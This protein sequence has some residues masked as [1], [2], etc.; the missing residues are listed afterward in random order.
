MFIFAL[1]LIKK[2]DMKKT[3]AALLLFIALSGCSQEKQSTDDYLSNLR[4]RVALLP[5]QWVKGMEFE[6]IVICKTSGRIVYKILEG[7][8]YNR[9]HQ[10]PTQEDLI[11]VHIKLDDVLYQEKLLFIWMDNGEIKQSFNGIKGNHSDIMPLYKL[12]IVI[13]QE[14]IL[15]IQTFDMRGMSLKRVTETIEIR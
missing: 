9:L 2:T 14:E 11:I 3:L 15:C 1:I 13:S 7:S 10:V 12:N 6:E 4:A 5:P 8:F